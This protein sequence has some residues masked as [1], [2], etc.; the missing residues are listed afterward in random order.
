MADQGSA[1]RLNVPTDV[2]ETYK[3]LLSSN[4]AGLIFLF[5]PAYINALKP[6]AERL[7][8]EYGFG[9]EKVIDEFR[10]L[11]AI[12]VFSFDG[13]ATKI[14]P[15][16]LSKFRRP[17]NCHLLFGEHELTRR[18]VDELWHA[19]ILDTRFYADLQAV[20]KVTLHHRPS[21]GSLAFEEASARQKRLKTMKAIYKAHFSTDPIELTLDQVSSRLAAQIANRPE[22]TIFARSLTGAITNITLPRDATVGQ[23]KDELYLN[24]G[25]HP[26]RLRVIFGDVSLIDDEALLSSY[27]IENKSTVHFVPK[28]TPELSTR[29]PAPNP[30]RAADVIQVFVRCLSGKTTSTLGINSNSLLRNNMTTPGG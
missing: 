25:I 14:S 5:S 29:L 27:S 24:M 26:D 18:V 19:A 10:R 22:I 11:L 9:I 28:P 4:T 17:N 1:M 7:V 13:D 20:L 30:S 6:T 15:T 3:F 8:E 12:K 23:F 21:G 2:L 16:P